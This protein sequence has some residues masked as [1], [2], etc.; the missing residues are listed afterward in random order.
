MVA[1]GAPIMNRVF[2]PLFGDGG[3]ILP[4]WFLGS[5]GRFCKEL[6]SDF[7]S[8]AVRMTSELAK[9]D[10]VLWAVVHTTEA[11]KAVLII[12]DV[13]MV[14]LFEEI[15]LGTIF[16]TKAAEGALLGIDLQFGIFGDF[17]LGDKF[18]AKRGN[19]TTFERG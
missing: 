8:V 2:A 10:C 16:G 19:P 18:V 9:V 12:E 7:E 15:L 4:G 5:I 3:E 14:G 11:M 6:I 17:D 1:I 13:N